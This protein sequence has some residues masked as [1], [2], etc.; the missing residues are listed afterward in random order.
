[1]CKQILKDG[2]SVCSMKNRPNEEYCTRHWKLITP[3]PPRLT[4]EPQQV[5]NVEKAQDL[6]ML[7]LTQDDD[8]DVDNMT[9]EQL[10][11]H[12][13]TLVADT[14]EETN[15]V[16]NDPVRAQQIAD[17]FNGKTPQQPETINVTNIVKNTQPTPKNSVPKVETEDDKKKK[18][19]DRNTALL[20]M[21]YTSMCKAIEDT[22][23]KLTPCTMDGF[24]DNMSNPSMTELFR[25]MLIEQLGTDDIVKSPT[26][27]FLGLAGLQVLITLKPKL[28]SEVDKFAMPPTGK[29]PVY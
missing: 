22:I 23:P 19:A 8:V 10:D 20:T 17:E 21:G 13:A 25:E 24:A 3:Q 5:P 4:E 28:N 11:A 15:A 2:Y 6:T 29:K 14:V 26:M 18:K 12:I 27:M 7:A 1:M 9:P 16:L